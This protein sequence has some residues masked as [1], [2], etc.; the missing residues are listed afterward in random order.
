LKPRRRRSSSGGNIVYAPTRLDFDDVVCLVM[1]DSSGWRCVEPEQGLASE[2]ELDT[3]VPTISVLL[4]VHNAAD[5]IAKAAES[6]LT[7]N[8]VALEVILIDDGSTDG[9]AEVLELIARDPRIRVI[10]HP[11]KGLALSLNQGI[12]VASAPFIA[13]MD[14]DD[15]SA[16]GRLD[17]QLRFLSDNPDVVLVGGQIRRI[18]NG[19]PR[20][21]SDLPL[22]HRGIVNALLQ[23]HHAICHPTV[24]I[25]K[26]ALD[27]VGGYWD[28]GFGEEWD[29]FLRL[30]EVGK[31]ANLDQ[32]VLD[33]TFHEGG[34]NASGMETMRTNIALAICNYRRRARGLKELDRDVYL[35]NLGVW[36][37]V[38]IGAQTRSLKAYRRSV[39]VGTSNQTAER[40]LLVEAALLWPPFAARRIV[41]TVSRWISKLRPISCPT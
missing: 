32:Q 21:A 13:R 6:V 26:S 30:S 10:S 36:E 15:I 37:R 38:R 9:T 2:T 1:R 22:G 4:P 5:T 20:S 3:S 40:L 33:Y 17:W 12:A 18:V 14:A 19:H 31:L 39:L 27:A 24:M 25:R 7:G 34:M 29:L 28:Q 8:D 35:D 23:G 16:P 11:N 41:R